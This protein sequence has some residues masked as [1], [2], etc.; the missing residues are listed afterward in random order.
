MSSLL[1]LHLLVVNVVSG[2]HDS[3]A[4]ACDACDV[5]AMFSIAGI[6]LAGH[7]YLA[8][9]GRVTCLGSRTISLQEG[10]PILSEPCGVAV[11][12]QT[13]PVAGVED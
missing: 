9:E 13:G 10:C 11:I 8:K 7:P 4:N 12:S 3:G 6:L 5:A 1:L 2:G